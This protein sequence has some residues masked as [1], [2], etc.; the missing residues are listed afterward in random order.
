MNH[1]D[2]EVMMGLLREADHEI[3][4][5]ERDADIII[6]NTC[7]VKGPTESFFRKKLEELEKEG[8]V[9]I[10]AGCIPQSDPGAAGSHSCIGTYQIDRVVDAVTQTLDGSNVR[11]L[12]R[13]HSQRLNLPKMRNNNIIEIIPINAGCI[14]SCSYCKTKQARG[15]LHSYQKED[16]IR[17][18]EQAINEGVREIWLTSQD[19][20]CY[21]FD[22]RPEK[23]FLPDL[24]NDI[25]DLEGDF[26]VR[27]GMG[28]PNNFMQFLPELIRAFKGEKIF[29]F[30]HCPIQSGSDFVLRAMRR[31]YTVGDYKRIINEFKRVIPGMTFSTDIICGFPT[32]TDQ[33]FQDTISLVEG[34][35]PAVMHI[36]K[37]WLRPGT[38]AEALEPVS[39]RKR[40][41]RSRM[42]REIHHRISGEENRKWLGWQG[43]VLVEGHGKNNTW[44]ARNFAYKQIIIQKDMIQKVMIQKNSQENMIGM[45]IDVRVVKSSEFYLHAE[46]L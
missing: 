33:Q 11:M 31:R 8:K 44:I 39:D 42:M 25:N 22:R 37:F 16:I 32:E 40:V 2:S 20:G 23:Y 4:G 18:A 1:S 12:D 46:P 19:T 7:T 30:L 45:F 21:G 9:V 34:T 38:E 14:D 27:V 5:D 36:S 29:K 35:R 10:V 24:I 28:N 43:R 26:M 13:V 17:Q 15:I 41:Q 3:I 6:F